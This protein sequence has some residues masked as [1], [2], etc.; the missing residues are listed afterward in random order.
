MA[1]FNTKMSHDF[2]QVVSKLES[3]PLPGDGRE[4]ITDNLFDETSSSE[5]S[6]STDGE[7]EEGEEDLQLSTDDEGLGLSSSSS[8]SSSDIGEIEI[9]GNIRSTPKVPKAT[10]Q[11]TTQ[12]PKT[13]SS[14]TFAITITTHDIFQLFSTDPVERLLSSDCQNLPNTNNNVHLAFVAPSCHAS[15][16]ARPPPPGTARPTPCRG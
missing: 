16:L 4:D 5:G 12:K 1:S 6:Y 14:T 15:R 13:T 2:S 11:Q 7:E 9:F 10:K 3:G 8:S